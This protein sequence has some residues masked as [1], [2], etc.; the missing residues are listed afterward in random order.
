MSSSHPQLR[1]LVPH[2]WERNA[3]PAHR[4]RVPVTVSKE[5]NPADLHIPPTVDKLGDL[6]VSTSFLSDLA[7]KII[8][9]DADSNTKTVAQRMHLE[10]LVV[11]ALLD[12]LYKER[13]LDKKGVVGAHSYQYTLLERGWAEVKRLMDICSYT[14]PAP[15]SLSAYSR[16]IEKQVSARSVV[17][18]EMLGRAIDG[19]VMSEEAKE[20][21]AL[22]ASSGR[23]LFLTGP[24]GNGKTATARGLVRA[25]P[26]HVWIPHAIE[27]DGQV[28]RIFDSHVHR[29]VPHPSERYDRRW[30]RIEP[31][32]VMVGG[33]LTIE[34]LDLSTTD[35]RRFYDAPFQVKAN[36]GV[37]V[38][39]DLGRQRCS[40]ADILNRW[41]VPLEY[42]IDYLTLGTGA[43]IQVP[44]KQILVFATNLK[45]TDLGDEAFLRRMGY[46]L[47]VQPPT[48][49]KFE[50]IFKHYATER[51][52]SIPTPIISRLLDR[53]R[54]ERRTP[55]CCDPRDLIERTIDLCKLRNQQTN[56]TE[57]M[58][59]RVW[60]GY[61]G[62]PPGS[63]GQGA[64]H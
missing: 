3:T 25:I 49:E 56:L 46:Q 11:E 41:I 16:F 24:S 21:L 43:K 42:Q 17:T 13:L 8:S 55:K 39:D 26:G 27:V 64:G 9:L 47:H 40:A 1:A 31:P 20:I 61:F 10:L 28:I 48:P 32:L 35:R 60:T 29:E 51:G 57:E 50:E 19:L 23:S 6:D 52:L 7:L 12:R 44:F 59:D 45:T 36:G 18:R 14:G 22:V 54:A 63:S 34:S 37:L 2:A 53:Y 15:V 30:V 38:I 58:L 62:P 5:P 33:E 4:P